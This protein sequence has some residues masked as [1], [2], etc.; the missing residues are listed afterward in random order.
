MA[1]PY[2]RMCRNLH[3]ESLHI[4]GK[5]VL[6]QFANLYV[7]NAEAR[8][9]SISGDVFTN[10]ICEYEMGQGIIIKGNVT[11]RD[12]DM[13]CADTIKAK[14]IIG[15][16]EGN[17]TLS[18]VT[19]GN[20]LTTDSIFANTIVANVVIGNTIGKHFGDVCG[21][22]IGGN[23]SGN[24]FDVNNNVNVNGDVIVKGNYMRKYSFR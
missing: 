7:A 2:G 5:L 14:T 20:V 8:N 3:G 4:K 18:N 16:I 21:N 17:L 13:L 9:I 1:G 12:G 11:I 6:D 10:G 24:H 19:V 22:V 23:V 15:N